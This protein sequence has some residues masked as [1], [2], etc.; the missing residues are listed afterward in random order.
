MRLPR[1]CEGAPCLS[2][3]GS[4]QDFGLPVSRS[5]HF[6]FQCCAGITVYGTALVIIG[7]PNQGPASSGEVGVFFRP[8]PNGH[9]Q[10]RELPEQCSPRCLQLVPWQFCRLLLTQFKSR[11]LAS[12]SSVLLA[13]T[14]GL[15]ASEERHYS[16]SLTSSLSIFAWASSILHRASAQSCVASIARL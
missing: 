10:F 13:S 15:G 6:A 12:L 16:D 1:P 8:G 2:H 14:I 11:N 3:A 4:C 9:F 7:F 5:S